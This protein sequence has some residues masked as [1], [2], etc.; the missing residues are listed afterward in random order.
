MFIS[1]QIRVPLLFKVLL[2]MTKGLEFD[3]VIIPQVTDRKCNSDIDRS[4]FYVS[5][6]RAMHKLTLTFVG[7]K[8]KQF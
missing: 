8:S 6:T 4:M 2:C 5:A 3:Q 1:F 7:M